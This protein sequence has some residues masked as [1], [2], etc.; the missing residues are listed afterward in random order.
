[1]NTSEEIFETVESL[2]DTSVGTETNIS[3]DEDMELPESFF[4][5]FEQIYRC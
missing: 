5:G 3:P 1:M 4:D 2:T